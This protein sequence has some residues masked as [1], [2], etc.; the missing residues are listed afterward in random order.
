MIGASPPLVALLRVSSHGFGLS[1]VRFVLDLGEEFI[2]WFLKNHIDSL[3][4]PV[5]VNNRVLLTLFER[6][7]TPVPK[8]GWR[9]ECQVLPESLP[10]SQPE[11]V[12]HHCQLLEAL[13]D[14]VVDSLLNHFNPRLPRLD[15]S[16]PHIRAFIW[17]QKAIICLTWLK[18]DLKS[19]FPPYNVNLGGVNFSSGSDNLARCRC[20]L[21]IEPGAQVDM[22]L[23]LLSIL[24]FPRWE[25]RFS[26]PVFKLFCFCHWDQFH[27]PVVSQELCH[28]G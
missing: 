19:D 5:L 6:A 28:F 26:N 23:A 11:L 18:C 20:P 9:V 22:V 16:T 21:I 25:C 24:T 13:L 8:I 17:F 2:D 14:L 4:H 27:Q 1:E 10:K 12:A 15:E 3:P 7:L